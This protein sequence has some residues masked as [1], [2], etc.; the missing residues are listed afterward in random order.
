MKNHNGRF[1]V[2]SFFLFFLL[3]LIEGPVMATQAMIPI[4]VNDEKKQCTGFF[5]GD[6]CSTCGVLPEGWRDIKGACPEGY[7]MVYF[8]T[9]G[10]CKPEKNFLCCSSGHSGSRGDCEDMV[11]NKEAKRCAFVEDITQCSALPVGWTKAEDGVDLCPVEYKWQ[12]EL[13]SCSLL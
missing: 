9:P 2:Q 11:L 13:L 8:E 10:R 7:A 3:L 1:L 4:S 5:G 6:E 12:E